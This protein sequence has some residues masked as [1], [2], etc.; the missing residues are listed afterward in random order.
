MP[1]QR[2]LIAVSLLLAIAGCDRALRTPETVP[3]AEVINK[4][5]DEVL[6]FYQ[7]PIKVARP[8]PDDAVCK[9]DGNNTVVLTPKNV[10]LTLK[11]VA[12]KANDATAGL[13]APLGVLSI[14]PSYAGSYSK[15]N[16]QAMEFTLAMS[17]NDKVKPVPEIALDQHPLYAAAR[18]MAQGLVDADHSKLPCLTPNGT[19]VTLNFD[20]VRKATGGVGIQLV[21]FKLGDKVTLTDEF[22]QTLELTFSDTGSSAQFRFETK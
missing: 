5:K 10:K 20:V 2:A 19:K 3:I 17:E 8:A 12:T 15:S 1:N 22:H 14:D 6:V 4:V 9:K 11:T 13:K 16:A 18:S 7:S 21:I